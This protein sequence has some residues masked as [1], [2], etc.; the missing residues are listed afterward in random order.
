[1]KLT[2]SMTSLVPGN[3]E[4]DDWKEFNQTVDRCGWIG[5]GC[6]AE[7]PADGKWAGGNGGDVDGDSDPAERLHK[8]R[9]SGRIVGPASSVKG[10][11]CSEEED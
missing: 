3:D 1:M 7:L 10:G 4:R 6:T 11:N 5:T 2:I 9:A 8:N